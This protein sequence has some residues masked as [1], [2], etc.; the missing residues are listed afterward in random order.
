MKFDV[1]R[2][3]SENAR[4]RKLLEDSDLEIDVMKE[5]NTKKW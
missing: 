5:I 2:H 4:L 1:S 3:W